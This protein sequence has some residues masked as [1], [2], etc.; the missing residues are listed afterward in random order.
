MN[1][2]VEDQSTNNNQRDLDNGFNVLGR[3]EEESELLK[4]VAKIVQQIASKISFKTACLIIATYV[5]IVVT[6]SAFLFFIASSKLENEHDN[7]IGYLQS[8]FEAKRVLHW[9]RL[10]LS[11]VGQ[12]F[13]FIL[14]GVAFLFYFQ[15]AKRNVKGPLLR[16]EHYSNNLFKTNNFLLIVGIIIFSFIASFFYLPFVLTFIFQL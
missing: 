4:E 12:M 10:V 5:I 1:L 2:Q 8:I 13:S 16:P 9:K 15:Y 11:V 7:N 14:H 3:K 6:M